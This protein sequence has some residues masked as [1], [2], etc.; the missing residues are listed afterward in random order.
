MGTVSPETTKIIYS[1]TPEIPEE[2]KDYPVEIDPLIG[3]PRDYTEKTMKIPG[4]NKRYYKK[5][6]KFYKKYIKRFREYE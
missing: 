2:F 4:G 5:T 3:M 6:L 1:S